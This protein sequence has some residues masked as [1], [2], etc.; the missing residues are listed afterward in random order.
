MTTLAD[1]LVPDQLGALWRPAASPASTPMGGR[2]RTITD[3]NCF[4]AIVHLARTS[5]PWRLLPARE[6]AVAQRRRAGVA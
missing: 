2:H 4:A 3:R 1:D 5:M 6:L